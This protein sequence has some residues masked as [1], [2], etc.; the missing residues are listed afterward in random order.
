SC[1]LSVRGLSRSVRRLRLRVRRLRLR[2]RRL[3]LR[4]RGLGLRVRTGGQVSAGTGGHRWR[5]VGGAVLAVGE[6]P[7][8]LAEEAAIGDEDDDGEDRAAEQCGTDA[9]D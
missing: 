4:A 9:G 1:G 5:F 3:R 2:A 6:Q 7:S 8:D